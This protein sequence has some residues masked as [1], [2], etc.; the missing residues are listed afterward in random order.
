MWVRLQLKADVQLYVPVVQR[1]DHRVSQVVVGWPQREARNTCALLR[2]R[3]DR[4]L[5]GLPF[6]E[7][8]WH[9][10][11]V[12]RLERTSLRLDP[13]ALHDQVE[14][15]R[16]AEIEKIEK[17]RVLQALDLELRVRVGV[18]RNERGRRDTK[19]VERV[20]LVVHELF[21][22]HAHQLDA[23]AHEP[24]VVDVGRDV[25]ARS[26]ETHPCL[27]RLRLRIDPVAELLGQVVMDDELTPQNALRFGISAALETAGLPQTAH[28]LLERIDDRIDVR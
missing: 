19:H 9:A 23:D 22:G 11:E 12:W 2:F 1:G 7:Q 14:D 25:W 15:M 17:L 26:R 18:R 27:E 6:P 20:L 24:D 13:Q 8:I 5:H 16:A 21:A 28:L 4:V 3:P 10:A